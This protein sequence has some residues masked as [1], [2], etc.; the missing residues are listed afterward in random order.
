MGL[1]RRLWTSAALVVLA[2]AQAWAQDDGSAREWN[3]PRG[4]SERSAWVDVA[5]IRSQPVVAW[6]TALPGPAS[7]SPVTWQGIVYVPTMRGKD[8]FVIS[9]VNAANGEIL[10][11]KSLGKG[12]WAHLAVWRGTVFA[13]M[14][15]AVRSYRFDGKSI[16]L[17]WSARPPAWYSQKTTWTGMPA[18]AGG[19]LVV[20]DANTVHLLD[21]ANGRDLVPPIVTSDSS[22]LSD[23]FATVCVT[24]GAKGELDI[25]RLGITT[26]IDSIVV[27]GLGTRAPVV[28]SHGIT[29]SVFDA[30][31]RRKELN[32]RSPILMRLGRRFFATSPTGF[33]AEAD[34]SFCASVIIGAACASTPIA[35]PATIVRDVAYGISTDSTAYAV[36]RDGSYSELTKRGQLPKGAK[37]GSA[38]AAG[39]VVYFGNWALDIASGRVLWCLAGEA[40]LG[41][42]VPVA[43][44]RAVF[45]T[46]ANELVSIAEPE[47][48]RPAPVGAGGDTAPAGP[49]AKDTSTPSPDLPG[50]ADGAFLADGRFVAGRAEA[51]DGGRVRVIPEKGDPQEFDREVCVLGQSAGRP[52]TIPEERLVLAAM[53][54]LLDRRSAAAWDAVFRAYAEAQLI[55]DA[56]RALAAGKLD[57]ISDAR[58]RELERLIAGKKEH[59]NADLRR[60]RVRLDEIALRDGF[61]ESIRAASAWCSARGLPGAATVLLARLRKERPDDAKSLEAARELIPPGFPDPVGT[62]AA[63]R[64]L[65]WATEIVPA[66]GEFVPPDAPER[67]VKRDAPWDKDVLLL[68]TLNVLL[69]TK[70]YDPAVV[71]ACLRHGEGAIRA[72]QHVLGP[73][74]PLTSMSVVGGMEVRLHRDR[75]SYLAEDSSADGRAETWSAGYYSPTSRVSRFYVP[76][77]EETTYTPLQRGLLRVL[78]HELTHQWIDLR[79][80]PE[81]AA[82]ATTPGYWCVEGVARFV[83]DQSV[84]MGRRAGRLDDV[85]VKSLDVTSQ[86]DGRNAIIPLATLLAM[87]HNHFAKLADA[88]KLEVQLRNAA[89]ISIV[90][91]RGLFYEQ[92]GALV[93]WLVNR[94]GSEGPAAFARYLRLRYRG[95]LGAD[96]NVDPATILGFESVDAMQKEFRAFLASLRR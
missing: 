54:D 96:A 69:V 24:P 51:L 2:V 41:P 95:R 66:G 22:D 25:A 92:S 35:N 77:G 70:S 60:K 63:L 82:S 55:A 73:A 93:F 80:Q 84:E 32:P 57:G 4:N 38:S 83:E 76:S 29:R 16:S 42:L 31:G 40:P 72:C 5:P 13:V 68:R 79:W 62:D 8:E 52:V 14:P 59:P 15:D 71:G 50:D 1:L 19:V 90:D 91:P 18:V 26:W 89:R 34:N 86:V 78:A 85:T 87:S 61:V 37:T 33:V 43:D 81:G 23:D 3:Q 45:L 17:G 94:R 67:A 7:A 28:G 20:P 49:T 88:P 21:P 9:A 65:A 46:T 27:T 36:S 47:R 58:A 10:A 53:E 30:I 64:W 12:E 39:D 6:R 74:A 44:G 75:A 48:L 56:A 11:T